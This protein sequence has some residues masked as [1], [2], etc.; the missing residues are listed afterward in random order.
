MLSKTENS[1]EIGAYLGFVN[2]ADYLLCNSLVAAA[3]MDFDNVCLAVL[4][5]YPFEVHFVNTENI[6]NFQSI[7]W[8]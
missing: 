3:A 6:N 8:S 2:R 5:C 4:E 7:E 1:F